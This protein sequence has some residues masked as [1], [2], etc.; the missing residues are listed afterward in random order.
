MILKIH[1]VNS[2][3][4]ENRYRIRWL[5]NRFQAFVTSDDLREIA[6]E[7]LLLLKGEPHEE[8][9]TSQKSSETQSSRLVKNTRG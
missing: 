6:R 2:G 4:G 1:P 9:K 5:I 3:D 7:I 8:W